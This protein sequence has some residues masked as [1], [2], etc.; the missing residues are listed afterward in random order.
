MAALDRR[1]VWLTG[2]EYR[3]EGL[4]SRKTTNEARLSGECWTTQSQE[5]QSSESDTEQFEQYDESYS[6]G[7]ATLPGV[8]LWIFFASIA[9]SRA[10]DFFQLMWAE[11]G[12]CIR[13]TIK[14]S[15]TQTDYTQSHQV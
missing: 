7:L 11:P 4:K 1:V 13:I 2:E 6:I 15:T 10:E 3:R 14:I 8:G 9:W 5:R 12:I